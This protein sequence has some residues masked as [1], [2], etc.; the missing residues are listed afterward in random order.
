MVAQ[1]SWVFSS[2]LS[3]RKVQR[4]SKA[5]HALVGISFTDLLV[6]MGIHRMFCISAQQQ[7]DGASREG[8]SRAETHAIAHMTV[9]AAVCL[10]EESR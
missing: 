6:L 4:L 8:P 2:T 3:S 7:S 9:T 5:S 10:D 1:I